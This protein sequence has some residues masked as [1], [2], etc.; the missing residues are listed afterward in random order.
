MPTFYVDPAMGSDSTGNGDE[1]KPYAT[2]GKCSAVATTSFRPVHCMLRAGTYTEH[3]EVP[4]VNDLT[5][6][7]KEGEMRFSMAQR[8]WRALSGSPTVR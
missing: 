5:I 4:K 7:A 1:A 3:L 6:E 2:V 8:C